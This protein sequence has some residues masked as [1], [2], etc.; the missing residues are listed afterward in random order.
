QSQWRGVFYQKGPPLPAGFALG[1]W[2]FFENAHM[3]RPRPNAHSGGVPKSEGGDRTPRP[4]T[5]PTTKTKTHDLLFTPN[6]HPNR[7]AKT[8][9]H[10]RR[11]ILLLYIARGLLGW[12]Y[13]SSGTGPSGILS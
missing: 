4:T 2:R 8:L 1:H 12:L 11:H 6:I 7:P 3:L 10:I 13:Q 9:P 5:A